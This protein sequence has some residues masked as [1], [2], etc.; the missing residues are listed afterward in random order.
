MKNFLCL[1]IYDKM[2]DNFFDIFYY[3]RCVKIIY[4]TNPWRNSIL[5]NHFGAVEKRAKWLKITF[6]EKDTWR[7]PIMIIMRLT[8][9]DGTLNQ[10]LIFIR[11]LAVISFFML[12][13]EDW[14]SSNFRLLQSDSN[15]AVQIYC[16]DIR[17][18]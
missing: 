5:F 3:N 11:F 8:N 16:C 4:I 6:E 9:E 13:R 15:L 14:F 18:I 2:K 1:S 17:K 12:K 7:L 10:H